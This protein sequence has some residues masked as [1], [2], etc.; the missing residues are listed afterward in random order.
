MISSIPE[1]I[2]QTLLGSIVLLYN[3]FPTKFPK[4]KNISWK[5]LTSSGNSTEDIFIKLKPIPIQKLS[6]DK[7]IPK[8]RA[9]FPSIQFDLSKSEE[10]GSFIILMVIPKKLMKIE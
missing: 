9:S 8:N 1:M 10:L 5:R 4:L 7:A 3:F 2:D 6:S